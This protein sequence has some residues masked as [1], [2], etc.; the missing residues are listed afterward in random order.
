MRKINVETIKNDNILKNKNVTKEQIEEAINQVITQI[1]IN[2]AYF[3]QDFP[4]PAT[5]DNIYM[6]MDNTEWTNG[7]YTGMLWLAYDYTKN[8]KYKK[9]AELQVNN[10]YNRIQKQIEVEHHDLGFLY[11]PSCV[12]AYK[13]VG[14]EIGKEAALLA[15]DKLIT[16]YQAV[17]KFIQAWGPLN[18]EAYYRF[19]IDCM[20]NIPLLYWATEQTG[21]NIYKLIADNH[22]NTSLENVI[23]EDAS[24]YHTFYMNPKTGEAVKGATRQGY[25]DSSSWAR[26]QVWGIYG[27]A[28]NYRHTKKAECIEYYNALTNYFINRLPKDDVCYWD[29]IFKDGDKQY[30]DSSAAAIAI[31]G[32]L[33]MQK[34]LP[35]TYKDKKLHQNAANRMML[36]LIENYMNK[37]FKK[38][39]CL[40][41][42]G[43]YSWHSG[44]GCDEG[45][46]W[47]DYFYFEALMRYYKDLKIY[48]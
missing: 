29:L 7:F 6:V 3:K 12:A 22:F 2:L 37:D 16:R 43:V 39:S 36:S 8:D 15:A 48:W 40:L 24:T 17:G 35:E 5:K 26:G 14:S 42:H 44:K 13:E 20:L 38:G 25:S 28:L 32:I 11:T 10:F 34:Y 41:K 4:T 46:I 45:N 47:G 27:V 1:D 30:K 19:I 21:K 31:C 18:E 9:I 33:E 23:R